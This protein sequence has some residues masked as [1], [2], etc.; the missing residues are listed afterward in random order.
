MRQY[1]LAVATQA[2]RFKRYPALAR[3]RGWEGAVEV[4]ISL[5]DEMPWP[6]VELEKSSGFPALDEQALEMIG[7]A[8]RSAPI[9]AGLRGKSL[10]LV[11]PVHFSLDD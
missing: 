5:S 11:L 4:S 8:S 2:G 10:R 9:P 3:E 6:V 1:K 7:R